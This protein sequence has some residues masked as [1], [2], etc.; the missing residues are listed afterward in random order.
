MNR[1]FIVSLVVIFLLISSL[2]SCIK[3]LYY[4]S[5]EVKKNLIAPKVYSDINYTD[6]DNFGNKIL[7]LSE[8]QESKKREVWENSALKEEML[9]FFPNYT[10]MYTFIELRILDT[11]KFKETLLA[12]IINAEEHYIAGKITAQHAKA[13]LS[14]F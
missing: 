4:A 3:D 10:A 7:L 9:N 11:G 2:S 13:M 1:I 12:Q 14:E 8:V 5:V 6:I